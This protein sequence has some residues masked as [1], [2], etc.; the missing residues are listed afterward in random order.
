MQSFSLRNDNNHCW[1]DVDLPLPTR[2]SFRR[3]L[4]CLLQHVVYLNLSSKL[5]LKQK[6]LRLINVVLDTV[7]QHN[8]WLIQQINDE[9]M[10]AGL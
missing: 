6:I 3:L 10:R 1:M 4:V 8:Q 7:Y 2:N 9:L 5:A